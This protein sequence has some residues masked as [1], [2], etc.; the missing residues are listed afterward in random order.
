MKIHSP[1]SIFALAAAAALL[2]ACTPQYPKCEGDQHCKEGEFCV[3]G[4]CQQCRSDTDCPD[5]GK[6]RAGR[7]MPKDYCDTAA[8]CTDGQACK[9]N[10][11]QACTADADC[12]EGGRCKGGRCL[13]PGQC[14]ADEDCPEG[15]ECQNGSCVAPPAEAVAAACQVEPVYFD[16]N[17]HVLTVEATRTLQAGAKCVQ[18]VK[19]RNLRVE[20]HCDPRGTEEYNL[21]LGDRRARSVQRYLERLGVS[22]GVMRP[23]S[24]GKLDASGTDVAGWARDR[25][26]IFIWE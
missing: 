2:V 4:M 20:G 14:L 16:Y 18:S 8:D 19:G 17:E 10:R 1:A 13:A 11:C 7:C 24:K 25:K 15:Q 23:V 9:G 3:N 6:C 26:V 5:G 22:K 21:A 12:G